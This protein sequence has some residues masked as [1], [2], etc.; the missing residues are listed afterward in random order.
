[1]AIIFTKCFVFKSDYLN[2]FSVMKK[3]VF[4]KL[5]ITVEKDASTGNRL[6]HNWDVFIEESIGKKLPLFFILICNQKIDNG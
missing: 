2:K 5:K 1:M 4:N 3:I 6:N